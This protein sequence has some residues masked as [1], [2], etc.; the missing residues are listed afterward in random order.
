ME[1]IINLI[2]KK[3][4][5]EILNFSK[6]LTE[7]ERFSTITLL[8]S[9]DI[10]RDIINKNGS[11]LTGQ[12]RNDF[13]ENRQQID[14]CLNYFLI[15]CVRNYDDLKKL[16][17]RH[18]YGTSNPFYSFI[19]TNNYEPLVNFYQ[20]FPPNYLNK[21][22]KDLSKERFR[23]IN[24]KILWKWY[25]NNWVEFD[26]EF[27]VRS[28]FNLQGFD[29][30][31]FADADFL[32][33]HTKLINKVFLKFHKYEIPILDLIK[34]NSID[35][36][37]GLSAKAN[38]YWTEVFKI[39]I[40]N[41][42]LTNRS[43]ITHLLESLLNNWKKPHL[44]WHV[45]LIELFEPTK[46]ELITNQ[47]I[48][49]S[50]LGTGQNS[51]IN[52]VVLKIKDIYS[53][54]QFDTLLF[55]ENIPII[56]SNDKIAKSI[57]FSLEIIEKILA[58]SFK[59]NI[60]YREQLCILLMQSDAK[61]QEK[62][63]KIL[64]SHFNDKDLATVV[65]PFLPNLKQVAKDILKVNNPISENFESV[66]SERKPFKEITPISNWDE[67]LMH[68]G[69]CIRTKSAIDIELFFDGI[70]QLQSIIPADYVKQIKP[71]TKPL[72]AKF[73]ESDTLTA[74]TLFLESWSTK[75]NDGLSK[76]DFK[77]IPFL[78]K[79]A[80]MTYLKLNDKNSLPF[81]STP[82]HEPFYVHPQIL[83]ERLLQYESTNT[84]VDLED[85]II[86]CNRILISELDGDYSEG[87][88]NIR[89]YYSDAIGYFLGESNIINFT[90]DTL[91]LW[92]QI[93]R[94]KNPNGNFSEF[95]K[96]KASKYLSVINPFIIGFKI[97]KDANEYATWYRLKLD[98]NWNYTWYNKEKAT[99]QETIFYNTASI[100]KASRVDIT[101][102]LSLNPNYIDALLCRYIPDTATGN[103]VYEF[104]ECLYPMQFI[105]DHQL[106]I[107]H[108]GWLY[109][110]VCLL[111][112]KKISRDLASEYINLAI[113]RNENLNE[114][115]IILS[116]LINDK[117]APVNRLIEYL[118]K[119][120][121]SKETKHLQ[122][123]IL[124]NCIRR[125]DKQNLPIN[126]KKIVQ[127]YKEL[128]AALNLN[129]DNTVEVK[130][131][132]IKK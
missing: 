53:D 42:A 19:S 29:N 12:K 14:S 70:I 105:L 94:I 56:F 64:I 20:L 21:V 2:K 106:R 48:L 33:A 11:N 125:F 88:K 7:D 60:D 82:T 63:A 74:F 80:K 34:A 49:F 65:T 111:F 77:Y 86:A 102:Q 78:G 129:I 52:Y 17:T 132:E 97:E 38:V 13:Y 89:G 75:N 84:K 67:L 117:F 73:Y 69:T 62:V 54:K 5:N 43:I 119:P 68:I 18:E 81:L 83:L 92:T 28:L 31:H 30:N 61:I 104:E 55:I 112:E 116:K 46:E 41:N 15:T 131:K 6:A 22:I 124:S 45:R 37:N 95:Q 26:E 107:Y 130:I 127:Y 85:L 109:V 72:F 79:K 27:F 99:R 87:I 35:Y 8:K 10:D 76:M 120:N 16:E 113:S 71:Y 98:N 3:N 100:E 39:L 50:I 122:F 9:I 1:R 66:I 59:I 51:L 44:D 23:N 118:D 114:F 128:Q 25:E 93:S 24:F 36:S 126:S 103:E 4:W 121:H 115:V 91:P 58:N 47:A 108:S 96:S 32:M 123:Q 101:N 90:N 110:A 57:L 40:K